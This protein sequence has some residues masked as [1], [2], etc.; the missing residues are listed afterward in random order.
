MVDIDVPMEITQY[1]EGQRIVGAFQLNQ[2]Q[3]GDKK[4][5]EYLVLVTAPRDGMPY[6]YDQIRVFTWNVRRHRYETAY[7]ERHLFGIFPV[8]V[9]RESFDKEGLLPV[10]VLHIQENGRI[11]E[12]KYKLNTPIVRRVLS[13]E[14]KRA[15]STAAARHQS[16]RAIR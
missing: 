11:L 7:R 13:E 12:R 10:F 1:A 4:M 5:S 15:A 8:I 9:S 14:Q 6:D 2:V 3:D 16:S